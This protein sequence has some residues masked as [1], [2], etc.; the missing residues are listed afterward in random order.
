[1]NRRDILKLALATSGTAAIA[2]YISFSKAEESHSQSMNEQRL[3][4]V[5]TSSG[6]IFGAAIRKKHLVDDPLY[7]LLVANQCGILVPELELKWEALRPEPDQFN[8]HDGDWLYEYGRSNR[9]AF[10]GHTLVWEAALPKWF[11]YTVTSQNAK[12]IMIDHITTVVRRYAGKMH[13]WDVVNEAF[14]IEDGRP[15]GLKITPWLQLIGPEYIEIAFHAAHKADPRATLVYNENWLE[16][17]DAGGDRKRN[18]VLT[19]LTRLKKNNVPV[20]GLGVQSHLYAETNVAGP[21]FE[22][23]LRQVSDWALSI[24]VTEMDVRDQNAPA[25][26]AVRDRLIAGQYHKYLSFMLQFPA[27][28]TVIMWGLSDRYTWIA[29]HNPRG[30]GLPVRPL[31]YDAELKPKPA[32]HAIRNAFEEARRR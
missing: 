3:R 27:V 30:D 10:R 20:H 26:I 11:Q 6:V 28:K 15:D 31:P 32:W 2:P 19:L 12:T 1:M 18:A 25:D 23:F 22:R 16:P 8:F 7:S 13:S 17:E 4:E 14:Q 5:A 29:K 9:M 21:K 24:M